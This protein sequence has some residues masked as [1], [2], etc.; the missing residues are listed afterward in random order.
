MTIFSIHF[1]REL[2]A[3]Q[4]YCPMETRAR[5]LAQVAIYRSLRIA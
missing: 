5:I 4:Q 2:L 3:E 1:N